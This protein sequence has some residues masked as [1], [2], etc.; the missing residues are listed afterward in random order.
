MFANT[1]M[2]APA[3]ALIWVLANIHLGDS[4]L[5]RI[6]ADWLNPFGLLLGLDGVILLAYIIAIPA[7]EIVV[8]TMMMVYMGAGMMVN[9]PSSSSAI[10]DLLVNGNGWTMLTAVNLMLFALLHNPCATTIMTIYKETKSLKWA[11][12]SVVMTLGTAFLVTF[13]TASIARLL[14]WA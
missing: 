6:I 11:T 10:F 2:S 4:N 5:A 14:G 8:P 1:Q 12:L 13:L 3:G 7:N 9:G